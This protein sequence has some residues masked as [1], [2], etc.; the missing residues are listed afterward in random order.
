MLRYYR[1]SSDKQE[2]RE[3][4]RIADVALGIFLAAAGANNS[5]RRR[6][7]AVLEYWGQWCIGAQELCSNHPRSRSL[8]PLEAA[9]AAVLVHISVNTSNL[10]RP[11]QPHTLQQASL[12]SASSS[13]SLL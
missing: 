1:V 7:D 10:P 8:L 13:N 12:H 3:T 11:L 5:R 9:G 4:C 6:L 2:G